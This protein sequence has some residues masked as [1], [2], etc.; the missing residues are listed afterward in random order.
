MAI[1][2][3]DGR[4]VRVNRQLAHVLGRTV[5]E[6]LDGA[7]IADVSHPDELESRLGDF[8]RLIAGE[9]DRYQR[10]RRYAHADGRTIWGA[11]TLSLVRDDAG[12]P[13]YAI[14]QL[15]DI[16]ARRAAEDRAGRR[17]AQQSALARLSQLALTEQR[18]PALARATVRSIT[19]ILDV[20]LAGLA[21]RSPDDDGLRFVIG[22]YTDDACDSAAA[23]LDERHALHTLAEGRPVVVRDTARETRFDVAGLVARGLASGMTVPVAGE[24]A[25]PFGVLGMYATAP[26]AFDDDDLAFLQS[27]ANVLTAALRRIAAERGL[28]HQSLHDPLTNLPNRA[29]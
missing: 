27:V 16:T 22:A 10:D 2:G 14:G 29:L 23:R 5:G 1:V 28:R 8:G 15:E 6:L 19:E 26:R 13:L 9:L 4:F 7:G 12:A 20:S 17:A 21:E 18:F 11:T 24:D 3:L 25:V